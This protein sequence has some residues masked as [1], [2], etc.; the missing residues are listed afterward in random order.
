VALFAGLVFLKTAKGPLIP[1]RDP[2]LSEA[3]EHKNYV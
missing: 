2:R 1:T 3:L